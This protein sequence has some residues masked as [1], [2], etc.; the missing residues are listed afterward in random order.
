[1]V[2]NSKGKIVKAF[3]GDLEQAF[4]EAVK[5][6]DEMYRIKVERRAD[7]VVVSA[8]GHP[9]DMN[10]YQAYK[11]LDNT[12]DVVKRGGVIILV[13]ECL[14]GHGNQ[15]FYEWMTRL[16]DLKNVEREVKHNF[17]LG[18]HKAYYLLKA[19]QSHQIIL[20]SSLP[21]FYASNVFKLKTARAV[22]DAL[23]EALKITGSASR[24][25]AIPQGSYTLPEFKPPEEIKS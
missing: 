2:E 22:N 25:W 9:S 15:V 23:T 24:V 14:E 6:V 1:V 4:L 19:L 11:A 17:A 12:L 21:D 13:A 8:G 3:A 10:L 18:G 16:G 7:I 20:V 5:L